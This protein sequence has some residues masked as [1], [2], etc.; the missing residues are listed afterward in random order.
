MNTVIPIIL[1]F[2]LYVWISAGQA[3]RKDW[4]MMV[5]WGAYALSQVGFL[6]HEIYKDTE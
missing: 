3:M 6:L 5:V 2:I 1:A 4:P